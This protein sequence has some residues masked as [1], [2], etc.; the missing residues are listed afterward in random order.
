VSPN[1]HVP[2]QELPRKPQGRA[3][4]VVVL[5]VG[6]LVVLE[7]VGGLVLVVVG[8]GCVVLVVGGGG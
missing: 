1:G 7:V 3:V 5:V 2:L 6:T 8:G 4:V